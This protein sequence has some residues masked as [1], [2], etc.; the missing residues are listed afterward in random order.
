MPGRQIAPIHPQRPLGSKSGTC[1]AD[2]PPAETAECG[3]GAMLLNCRRTIAA[4][5]ATGSSTVTSW[6]SR[7]DNWRSSADDSGADD[8]DRHRRRVSMAGGSS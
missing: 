4:H 6:P 8:D 2:H 1:L 5:G 3:S 7:C